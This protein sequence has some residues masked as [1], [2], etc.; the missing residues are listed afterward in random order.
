VHR[1]D[2]SVYY[3]QIEREMFLLL[4]ALRDGAFIADALEQAFSATRL[5]PSEQAAS[6]QRCFAHASELAGYAFGAKAMSIRTTSS[7]SGEPMDN[8]CD[9][10]SKGTKLILV[11]IFRLPP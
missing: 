9:Q 8:V 11:G 1:F 10:A 7:C 6:V 5:T 4:A 3:R 2:D